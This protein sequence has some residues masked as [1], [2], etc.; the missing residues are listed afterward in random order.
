MSLVYGLFVADIFCLSVCLSF[1][2]LLL[3]VSNK[4]V[5]QLG[6]ILRCFFTVPVCFVCMLFVCLFSVSVE[7]YLVQ[8]V[9]VLMFVCLFVCL[10]VRLIDAFN[11]IINLIKIN[12]LKTNQRLN[13]IDNLKFI[14]NVA[15]NFFSFF[16]SSFLHFF[17]SLIDLEYSIDRSK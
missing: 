6:S 16:L 11:Q 7:M 1:C 10:F 8:L 9:H 17:L 2:L 5:C 12:Q 15:I 13:I 14:E 3:Y 4:S